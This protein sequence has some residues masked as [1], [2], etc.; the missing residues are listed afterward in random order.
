MDPLITAAARTLAAES[1][2]ANRV[3]YRC[4]IPMRY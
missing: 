3:G 1:T 4:S 2:H